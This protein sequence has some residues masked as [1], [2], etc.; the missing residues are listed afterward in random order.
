MPTYINPNKSYSV[1]KEGGG[2]YIGTV[3]ST[4]NGVFVEIP[5]VAPGQSLGPCSTSGSF[6]LT[7]TKA[8]VNT[9]TGT[10]Q[11]VTNVSLSYG[12]STPAVGA[13]VICMFLDNGLDQVAI[14]G[15]VG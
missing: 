11:A 3:I 2:T 1:P 7:L 14:V 12:G 4:T 5:K 13:Q 8:T 6:S 15:V 9:P 10:I